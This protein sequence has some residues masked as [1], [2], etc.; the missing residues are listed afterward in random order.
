MRRVDVFALEFDWFFRG[1]RGQ[2]FITMLANTK[3]LDFFTVPTIQ[4]SVQF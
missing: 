1:V 3:N 4:A 2:R